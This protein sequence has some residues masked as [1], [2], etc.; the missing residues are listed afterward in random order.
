[1]EEQELS[2][3][4]YA[5]I[6]NDFGVEASAREA[7]SVRRDVLDE[8]DQVGFAIA[9]AFAWGHAAASNPSITEGE[10]GKLAADAAD[11]SLRAAHTHGGW[12]AMLAGAA[13]GLEPWASV[14]ASFF[15][16]AV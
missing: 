8:F 16:A 1:L 12:E 9:F 6:S 5:E 4:V 3:R 15:D 13:S 7:L 11:I 2:R 14:V 10:L